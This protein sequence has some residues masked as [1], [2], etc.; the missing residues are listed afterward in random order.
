VPAIVLT[1]SA[2]GDLAA[3]REFIDAGNPAQ[4]HAFI[5]LIDSKLLNLC[6]RPDLGLRREELLNRHS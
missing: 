3:I 4:T 2:N 5:D 6:R 1:P